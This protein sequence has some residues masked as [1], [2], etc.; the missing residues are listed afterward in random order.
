MSKDPAVLFYTGDFLNGSIDLTFEERGQYIT[1]LCLQHQKGHLS[2]KTIRLS[3]GSVS[4][5]VLKKFTLDIDGN[6][7]NARMDDEIQKRSHFIETRRVNGGKG[8]RPTKAND[9]PNGYPLAKANEKLI[10]NENDNEDINESINNYKAEFENFRKLY[11]GSKRGTDTEFDNLRKKHKDHKAVIPILIDSLNKQIET[12]IKLKDRAMF[13][14][15]WK[16]L[17]TW[18]NQRCWE[19]EIEISQK[20]IKLAL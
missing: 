10:E 20:T 6:Y 7:F 3:V 5:D 18:I 12:R 2:E 14:P 13:V 16:H 11:P 9:K 8:G 19:E 4:V 15:E 1:L 17:Q